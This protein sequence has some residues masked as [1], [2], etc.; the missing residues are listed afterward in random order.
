MEVATAVCPLGSWKK[1]VNAN[2]NHCMGC[3]ES[4]LFCCMGLQKLMSWSWGPDVMSLSSVG[5]CHSDAE[6]VSTPA[7]VLYIVQEDVLI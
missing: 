1:A 4:E 2:W 7:F 5:Q 3:T 6:N